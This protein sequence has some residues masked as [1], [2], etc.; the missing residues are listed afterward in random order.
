MMIS[1]VSVLVSLFPNHL[2]LPHFTFLTKPQTHT[3]TRIVANS[4]NL[5]GHAGTNTPTC[6]FINY[7]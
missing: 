4:I 7:Q 3:L 6:M 2:N 1:L 5:F